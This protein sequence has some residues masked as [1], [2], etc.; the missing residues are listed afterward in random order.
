M[1]LIAIIFG[2]C[3][4]AHSIPHSFKI[5]E[6]S[7]RV[8]TVLNRVESWHTE[9]NA[10]T[11]IKIMWIV[12]ALNS[13]W[14]SSIIWGQPHKNHFMNTN[15]INVQKFTSQFPTGASHYRKPHLMSFSRRMGVP[16]RC[17]VVLRFCDITR[18]GRFVVVEVVVVGVALGKD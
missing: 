13:L 17:V 15:L 11:Y 12:M 5:M 4:K 10:M 7:I 6:M 8:T 2:S 18:S 16:L 9:L 3:F 14:W 1:K